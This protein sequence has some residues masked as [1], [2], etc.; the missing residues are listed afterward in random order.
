LVC[1]G[2]QMVKIETPSLQEL[3]QEVRDRLVS[4]MKEK[5]PV[6]VDDAIINDIITTN[7]QIV[8]DYLRNL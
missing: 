2:K 8:K 3:P 7:L 1:K 4:V 6:D 5:L